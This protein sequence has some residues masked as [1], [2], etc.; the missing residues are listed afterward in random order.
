M[1]AHV[2]GVPS[3][4]V[5][6]NVRRMGGGFGGK[7]TQMNLFA[8]VAAVA[9]KRWNRTVK[10]R[11]DRDDDMIATGKRHDFV[12]DYAVGF[13]DDGRI[14]SVE[15]D[16]YARCG[17]SADLSG[18]V[19]D[20][21]LFHADNAY[22]YPD[23]RISSHPMKTNTVSNT[24]FRGFGGPQGA[25][26]AERMVEEIAYALGMDPLEVRKR[27]LYQN[28]QLTPYHQTVQDQ[29]LP[30]IF[31]ELEA[32]SD[33]HA[34]RQA[35]LDWNAKGGVIRKGIAL[36]PVKFGISFTATWFNQAGALIHVY[37]DGSIHLNHGGTEMGQGLNTKVAQVVAEAF[38]CDLSRIKITKTTTEKVPNTSATAA[39]SGTDLNGMAALDAAEQIKAR[40]VTFVA[41]KWQVAPDQVAFVPGHVRAGDQMI[42]FAQVIRAA[43]MARIQLSAAGFYKTPKIHWDR[44]TGQGRPFYYFAYGAAVAEVSV[45]TLTGE[46][47]I[48]RA[49]VLHDVGRSLNPVLDRGQV[50]GAFVQGA[51]WLTTEELWWDAKGRLRTHAPSTYKVPLASDSPRIFNVALADWSEASERT[52]KR[53]K[54]VGEPPFV[55]GISVFEA[56]N[57]AVASVADYRTPARLD[58]P[59]TPERVLMAVE[60]LRG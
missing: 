22:F 48:D 52:I 24:A 49:D 3:N 59:A 15:G 46:Y 25:I 43:Y 8:C 12:V 38:Q 34:R 20:R 56:I 58:A 13:D 19:T 31:D 23:V 18:P 54:A 16:F 10:I 53:S 1:V 14:R 45:D 4:A 5:V 26:V 30:R 9:A 27:N 29:I 21:A 17:F 47:V 40:L 7:E 41:E 28:G 2:L 50:E 36:T 11:P 51:G 39:S 44:T 35:V 57:M 33:Y 37:S 60:R 32:S 55:L 6:V 42:P